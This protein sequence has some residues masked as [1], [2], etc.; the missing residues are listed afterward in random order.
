MRIRIDRAFHF[1]KVVPQ[2]AVHTPLTLQYSKEA[3]VIEHLLSEFLAGISH[4]FNHESL[5]DLVVS[6]VHSLAKSIEGAHEKLPDNSQ[7]SFIH[8]VLSQG[9]LVIVAISLGLKLS[10]CLFNLNFQ[11]VLWRIVYPGSWGRLYRQFS[12]RGGLRLSCLFLFLL[13]FHG[14]NAHQRPDLPGF[15]AFCCNFAGWWS[16]EFLEGAA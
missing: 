9:E 14:S 6:L 1:A 2:V 4:E 12:Y 15:G 11:V 10:K 13:N 3:A 7:D 8:D 16:Y 5:N